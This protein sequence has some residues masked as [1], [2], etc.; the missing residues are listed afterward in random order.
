MTAGHLADV[1]GLRAGHL[2]GVGDLADVGGLRA[3]SIVQYN[4]NS[5]QT[6]K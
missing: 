3:M 4:K 2:A 5:E 6:S 1:G